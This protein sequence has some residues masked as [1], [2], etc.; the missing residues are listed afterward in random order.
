MDDGLSSFDSWQIWG[1]LGYTVA[2]HTSY[3]HTPEHHKYRIALPLLEP[4]PA[5]DWPR[6]AIAANEL[7][8]KVV[9]VGVL[10]VAP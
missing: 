2:A 5:S 1:K 3:S 6:A 9:G 8:A 10:I 4:I 7:W